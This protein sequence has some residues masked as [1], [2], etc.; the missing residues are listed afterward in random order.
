MI[1]HYANMHYV[2]CFPSLRAVE[3]SQ[4]LPPRPSFM[5]SENKEVFVPSVLSGLLLQPDNER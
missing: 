5:A 2:L 3:F 4:I 1:M